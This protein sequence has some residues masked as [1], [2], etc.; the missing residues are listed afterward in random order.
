MS[1][2]ES[3]NFSGEG[4]NKSNFL[5]DMFLKNQGN[6]D[7]ILTYYKIEPAQFARITDS[8]R[9]ERFQYLENL[10]EKHKFSCIRSNFN[11]IRI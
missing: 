10:N 7:L 9:K 1:F 3:L 8:I 4:A 6:N 11:K 5:L 2:D